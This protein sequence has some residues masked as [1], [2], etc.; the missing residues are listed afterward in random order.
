[1]W[2]VCVVE[3]GRYMVHGVHGVA[4]A[5]G[6]GVHGIGVYGIGVYGIGAHGVGARG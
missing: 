1:M 2:R 6:A 5:Q 3:D 4:R